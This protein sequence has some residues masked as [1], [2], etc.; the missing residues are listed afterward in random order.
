MGPRFNDEK[1]E[2]IK[3][4]DYICLTSRNEGLPGVIL[5]SASFGTPCIISKETNLE[6]AVNKFNSGITI[7]NNT[8]S[9]ICQAILEA[10]QTKND[11]TL[12]YKQANARKMIIEDFNWSLIAKKHI[13]NYE[14]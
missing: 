9:N 14:K 1:N 4:W 6:K 13:E 7:H 2:F 10:H 8:A 3:E 5:E 11:N 12:K